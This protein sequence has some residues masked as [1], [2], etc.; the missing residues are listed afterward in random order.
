MKR[1][2]FVILM[3]ACLPVMAQRPNIRDVFKAM[4]D[5]LT[6]YLTTNNRLDLMDFLD[7][8]MKSSV[9]NM[10]EG[11]TEMVSLTDDSLSLVMNEVMTL[12]LW[13]EPV[14]TGTVICL[15]RTYRLN[16]RQ[17]QVVEERF[18]RDWLSIK[19][20]TSISTLLRR[21]EDIREKPHF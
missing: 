12:D 8:S 20:K 9:G 3:G 13:T 18:S 10:M 19:K 14:D 2:L 5:S 7:A 15:R 6:P 21:D 4:P 1:I 16:S 17:Q 11:Q